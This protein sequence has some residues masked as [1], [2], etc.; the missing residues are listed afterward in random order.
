MVEPPKLNMKEQMCSLPVLSAQYPAE[1]PYIR[2][3][4]KRKTMYQVLYQLMRE[5]GGK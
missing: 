2:F 5:K 3:G 1:A 4:S